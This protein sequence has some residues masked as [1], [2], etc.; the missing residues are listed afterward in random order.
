[1]TC[2]SIFS[3]HTFHTTMHSLHCEQIPTSPSHIVT[4]PAIM[5]TDRSLCAV[6]KRLSSSTNSAAISTW[7][8]PSLH[9]NADLPLAEILRN[10]WL[11]TS[12]K[13][14]IEIKSDESE[15]KVVAPLL[16]GP[17]PS[18]VVIQTVTLPSLLELIL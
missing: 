10:G 11:H 16:Y 7:T 12:Y 5:C 15:C 1:M 14:E 3:E 2:D 6:C 9:G 17:H 4:Q 8:E 18:Y 13:T